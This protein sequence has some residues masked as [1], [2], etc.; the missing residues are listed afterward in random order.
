[1]MK[2]KRFR[3]V[4]RLDAFISYSLGKI[5]FFLF[6]N[7]RMSSMLPFRNKRSHEVITTMVAQW[8]RV[9]WQKLAGKR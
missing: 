5:D 7:I 8:C 3:T 4:S 6:R 2:G 1:M 9:R